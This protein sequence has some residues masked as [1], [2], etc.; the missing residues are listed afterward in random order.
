MERQHLI[1]IAQ[2]Y[3]TL[4][5]MEATTSTGHGRWFDQEREACINRAFAYTR[6]AE[7]NLVE[8][9]KE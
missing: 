6:M 1:A 7:A 4:A 3:A 2:V 5:L 9:E 8:A